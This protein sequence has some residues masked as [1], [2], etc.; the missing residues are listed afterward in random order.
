MKKL[1]AILGAVGLTTTGASSVVACS[2]HAKTEEPSV[3]PRNDEFH[4][5]Q[6]ARLIKKIQ[7]YNTKKPLLIDGDYKNINSQLIVKMINHN[8]NL[9]GVVVN[10]NKVEK[11]TEPFKQLGTAVVNSI[12]DNGV[13]VLTTPISLKYSTVQIV[14]VKA[15]SN[16][17]NNI[18][19]VT[20]PKLV[21]V[22]L[23]IPGIDLTLGSLLDNSMVPTILNLIPTDPNLASNDDQQKWDQLMQMVEGLAKGLLDKELSFKKTINNV[24]V[25]GNADIVLEKVT[26]KEIIDAVRPDL[27]SLVNYVKANMQTTHNLPLLLFKYLLSPVDSKMP[28]IKNVKDGEPHNNFEH[29]LADLLDGRQGGKDMKKVKI[30]VGFF[31]YAITWKV[32]S[33]KNFNLV[34]YTFKSLVE[35]FLNNG[36]GI[37]MLNGKL[38]VKV[39]GELLSFKIN[40][41]IPLPMS[42]LSNL[43]VPILI[44]GSP[45]GNLENANVELLHGKL[46]VLTTTDGATWHPAKTIADLMQAKDVTVSGENLQFKVSD[47]TDDSLS[48]TTND[49]L[50][51]GLNLG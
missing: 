7:N 40:Q 12:T 5:K 26:V 10:V 15:I 19:Q 33:D 8:F 38:T 42:L 28:P 1:L 41:E 27:I 23:P 25:V 46:L 43:I 39:K 2:N 16:D 17:L 31:P 47:K 45:S 37:D 9:K 32:I 30:K 13:E 6:V 3:D 44:G 21:D 20:N 14:N 35:S 50:A 24:P 49:N 29:L 11:I 51:I 36:E 4:Q 34:E 18:N 22:K 48:I